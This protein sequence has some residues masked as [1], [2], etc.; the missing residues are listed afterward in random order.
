MGVEP[1]QPTHHFT[2]PDFLDKLDRERREKKFDVRIVD[3][4]K[5]R[6][7]CGPWM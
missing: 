6:L 5:P 3:Q 7:T 1:G 4:P 2:S